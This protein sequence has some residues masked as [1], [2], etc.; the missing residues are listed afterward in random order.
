M[1]HLLATI[2]E[3]DLDNIRLAM[4]CLP[5][6]YSR[7]LPREQGGQPRVFTQNLDYLA[8]HLSRVIYLMRIFYEHENLLNPERV[9][10]IDH[11]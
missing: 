5:K 11:F 6:I 8:S 3:D 7:C 2:E 10:L 9:S 1:D 4:A